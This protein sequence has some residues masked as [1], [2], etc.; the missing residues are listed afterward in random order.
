MGFQGT[1]G[2]VLNKEDL[3]GDGLIPIETVKSV[4]DAKNI[5]ALQPSE[6]QFLLSYCDSS[7]YGFVIISNFHAKLLDLAQETEAEVKL[8][9]FAKSI[10]N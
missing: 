8:R 7:N 1:L 9:R 6:L 2:D 4:V 10:G 3:K 5:Q